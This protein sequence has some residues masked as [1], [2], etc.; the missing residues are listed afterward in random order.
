MVDISET[1]SMWYGESEKR[2]KEIFD[3]YRSAVE[4]SEITP[5]LLFNEADAVIGKRKELN[6]S[7][8]A[9]DQTDDFYIMKLEKIRTNMNGSKY[10]T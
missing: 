9:V 10:L 3:S 7:S 1:K 6:S 8:R 5:I 4:K 2:I